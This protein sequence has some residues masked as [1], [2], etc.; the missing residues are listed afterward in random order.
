MSYGFAKMH[1]I[2]W[3]DFLLMEV[4]ANTFFF[5]KESHLS[6]N[7]HVHAYVFPW[8]RT[9]SIYLTKMHWGN[10]NLYDICQ[11]FSACKC[12]DR[13]LMCLKGVIRT[14][15]HVILWRFVVVPAEPSQVHLITMA[16][17]GI[18]VHERFSNEGPAVILFVLGF[19][20]QE[21]SMPEE[22]RGLWGFISDWNSNEWIVIVR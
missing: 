21:R 6:Q 2:N 4:T 5:S 17:L 9:I 12:T 8:E 10:L 18:W 19:L 11:C 22:G 1:D 13:S 16:V 14:S 15:N 3:S 20:S 7:V